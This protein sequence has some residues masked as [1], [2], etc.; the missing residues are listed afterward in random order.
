MTENGKQMTESAS[1]NEDAVAN[2]QLSPGYMYLSN[3]L[4]VSFVLLQVIMVVLIGL[5]LASGVK[6]VRYDEQALVLLF[7]KIRGAGEDRVLGPGL[8]FLWPYPIHEIVKIPVQRKINIPLNQFWYY[9]KAGEEMGA[10]VDEPKYVGPTLNPLTEGYSLVRGEKQSASAGVTEGSDYN[11]LHSKWVLTYQITEPERFYKHCYVET[12]R[13]QAGQNYGDVIEENISR[14]LKDLLADAVVRAM[15]N[16]TIEEAM[17]ERASSVTDHVKRLL[18]DKL[19]KIESGIRVIDVQRNRIAV[20]RQ[21]EAAF[22]A[23]HSAVQA[24]EKAISEAKLYAEKT[25]SEAAGPVANELHKALKDKNVDEQQMEWLWS[26][27]AGKAQ[28]KI[29]DARAYRTKVVEGARA[30]AEYLRRILPEYRKR[31][32]LVIQRIYQDAVEQILDNADEKILIQPGKSAETE[33]RIL[34]NRDPTI[35]PKP[36]PQREK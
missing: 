36:E 13:I 21:V 6:T 4:K 26:Q 18:Q 27:L 25:L 24:R 5:F 28:E 34:V 10:P 14:M 35:K 23:A 12:G 9:Q 32:K 20:P 31:P 19:D 17:Y 29:A 11:I 1:K 30:N 8:H 16:Y 22:Q 2:Q 15:V 3:A 7:G 33:L